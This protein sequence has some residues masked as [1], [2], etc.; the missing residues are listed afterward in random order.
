[1]VVYDM[2]LWDEGGY[3]SG[4][5]A[6]PQYKI[7]FYT[8]THDGAG[9]GT[10]RMIDEFDYYLNWNEVKMLEMEQVD[11]TWLDTDTLIGGGYLIPRKLQRHLRKIGVYA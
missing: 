4:Y 9:Y 8:I 1:M 3:L 11:D 7:N 5:E 10:G 6:S 2:N